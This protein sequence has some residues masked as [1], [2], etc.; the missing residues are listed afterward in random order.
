MDAITTFLTTLWHWLAASWEWL[1]SEKGK[2]IT[3]AL[4][5]LATIIPV[6]AG[7]FIWLFFRSRRT[8]Q[9]P[10]P[11]DPKANADLLKRNRQRMLEKVRHMW[12]EG[13]LEQS[14]YRI[15]RLELGY[16]ESPEMVEHSWNLVVE[17]A[18]RQSEPIRAGTPMIELFD[19]FD[20]TLLILGAPGAG[21]TTLLL[22]LARDLIER[23][24]NESSL[25]I[26]IIFN[27]S[28]WAL[29]RP[30]I[31]DWL[32]DELRKRYD[33]PEKIAR[34]WIENEAILPLLDGLDE[35]AKEHRNACVEAINAYREN[36][37]LLPIAICSRIADYETLTS[38]LKLQHAV[39]V[40]PLT[41]EQVDRYLAEAGDSL[42]PVR[43]LVREDKTL[44][45][46][47]DNPLM[48]SIM[49]LAFYNNADAA[50]SLEDGNI[51]NRRDKLFD[52]Y[53]AAM[54]KR[55][56]PSV[57]YK[58]EQTKKWI[59]RLANA[60]KQREQTV[61]YIEQLQPEL[62]PNK[63]RIQFKVLSLTASALVGGLVGWLATR[64]FF[65]LSA[66]LVF[67]LSGGLSTEQLSNHIKLAVGNF[68]LKR[69]I[70]LSSCIR[71]TIGNKIDWLVVGWLVVWPIYSLLLGLVIGIT[72]G[73]FVMIIGW[74]TGMA[75]VLF[76]R[77]MFVN[78]FVYP[79]ID[80]QTETNQ[81]VHRS[82]RYA[83]LSGIIIALFCAVF[84][85]MLY[86][87]AFRL[88][89]GLVVGLN[90]GIIIGLFS[91][92]FL[93]GYAVIQH[94][95]LRFLL[96]SEGFAPLRY[97]RFLDYAADLLF[98]RKVGGGYIFVHRMIMEHFAAMED[99]ESAA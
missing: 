43:K 2:D 71:L 7:I 42:E 63:H 88:R 35:V 23:A 12:V 51:E 29:Q 38:K 92:L 47:L 83:V 34:F 18:G 90:G 86:G 27:L 94:Y 31:A 56:K 20:K 60:M 36:N 77:L 4:A 6:I 58:P 26:P 45:E 33:V 40:Q 32:I 68:D 80:K 75:V 22:E 69:W 1:L 66:G 11:L 9:Q 85:G 28:S 19:R 24:E 48:L 46:L 39:T 14:L 50:T 41:P 61:F 93:G 21:K 82:F 89:D 91:G 95:V 73:L 62:L 65:G 99:S 16:K 54:F 97:V 87:L 55:R 81:G 37:G 84:F 3:G 30:P 15:A 59:S 70:K 5:N 78:T 98:L 8:K 53:I 74:L 57:P 64:L 67:G 25:P 10:T 13:V 72:R 52:S 49:Q 44:L 79:E 17:R 96:W 76:F